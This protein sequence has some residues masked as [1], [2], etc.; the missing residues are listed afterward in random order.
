MPQRPLANFERLRN[1][2]K[3]NQISVE[4]D[5]GSQS[6]FK[7]RPQRFRLLKIVRKL[8][9]RIISPEEITSGLTLQ[10]NIAIPYRSATPKD[11]KEIGKGWYSK[12]TSVELGGLILYL[13]VHYTPLSYITAMNR[14]EALKRDQDVKNYSEKN[15]LRPLFSELTKRL[16]ITRPEDPIAFLIKYLENRNPK[17]VVCVQ[18]YEEERRGRI[19]TALANKSNFSL[20]NV[21]VLFGGEDYH[22]LDSK[23]VSQRVISEINKVDNVYRGIVI[24]GFPNNAIQVD[25]LQKAGILPDRYFLLYNDEPAIRNAYVKRYGEQQSELLID[26]NNLELKELKEILGDKFDQLPLTNDK[27]TEKINST[28]GIRLRKVMPLDAP[29]IVVLHPPYL[30][31]KTLHILNERYSFHRISVESVFRRLSKK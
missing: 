25:C 6:G 9:I 24:S 12:K 16:L 3:S 20:I 30:V 15:K 29:R 13:V 10:T 22:F 18:G 28:I 26:R 14:E 4:I 11:L 19:A 27:A 21:P 8:T 2:Q 5:S 17:I 23:A 31:P 1:S 7:R